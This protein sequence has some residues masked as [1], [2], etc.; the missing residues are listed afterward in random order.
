MSGYFSV[1]EILSEE[2]P[3]NVVFRADV[4]E[5][6][7]LAEN[8]DDEDEAP[9]E[10]HP[11]PGHRNDLSKGAHVTVP[12]WLARALRSGRFVDL[13]VRDHFTPEFRPIVKAGVATTDLR[14]KSPFYYRVGHALAPMLGPGREDATRKLLSELF[15]NRFVAILGG[16]EH[17]VGQHGFIKDQLTELEREVFDDVHRARLEKAEWWASRR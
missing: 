17:T 16:A 7:F 15:A 3:I 1:D 13:R 10:G 8:N 5:L 11:A 9:A 6:G 2:E 4:F 12:L 14:A